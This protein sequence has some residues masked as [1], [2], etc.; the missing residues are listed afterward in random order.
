M[1]VTQSENGFNLLQGIRVIVLTLLSG[2]ILFS[3]LDVPSA[4]AGTDEVN[5]PLALKTR[6][7]YRFHQEIAEGGLFSG[8]LAKLAKGRVVDAM[9]H[10]Q[11]TGIDLVSGTSYVRVVSRIQGNLWVAEWYRWGPDGLLLG[12]TADFETGDEALMV[13]PQKILSSRLKKGESWTWKSSMAPI[14]IQV[15]IVGPAKVSVPAGGFEAT[16]IFHDMTIEGEA[17]RANVQQ[18]RW[19][20]S[21]IGY[22]KQETKSFVGKR[23]LST[24]VLTLEKFDPGGGSN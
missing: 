17:N 20:V 21:G 18:N 23:M 19:F 9:V 14:K 8:M 3:I 10:S 5:Y 11:V 24:T 15:K 1:G 6:W 2:L 16:Q 4:A 13:P 7:T 12:K 22:A